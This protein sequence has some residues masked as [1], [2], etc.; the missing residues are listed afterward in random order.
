M[1]LPNYEIVSTFSIWSLFKEYK[2]LSV[3][4]ILIV[5]VF[6]WF[7]FKL[8]LSD[9]EN[10][11]SILFYISECFTVSEIFKVP[12]ETPMNTNPFT[13]DAAF[14]NI[15]NHNQEYQRTQKAALSYSSTG[16]YTFGQVTIMQN[17]VSKVFI[18][19]LTNFVGLFLAC[20]AYHMPLRDTLS[21]AVR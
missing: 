15:V 17:S 16:W 14:Q 4:W 19:S 5:L 12:M 3:D 10:K 18:V 2:P 9:V 7:I 8:S 11:S 1:I 20:S 13:A 6:S 21:K